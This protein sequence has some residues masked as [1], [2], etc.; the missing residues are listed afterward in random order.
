MWHITK[1]ARKKFETCNLLPIHE[2]D[3]EW[4]SA[5]KE[6][7]EEGEDLIAFLQQELEEV[8]EDLIKV[9]PSRF[10]PYLENGT[11]NQPTLPKKVRDD[12]LT[13]MR[14]K[15][16]EF[17]QILDAAYKNTNHAVTYLPQAVQEVFEE[18]LHD[19]TIERIERENHTL[20]LYINT[21]G[22]F[23]SKSM[24]HLILKDVIT[25]EST[26]PIQ[27]GQWFIYNELQ[28]T[29]EG[30]AFRVLYD[31]PDVEW[32]ITMKDMD[33]EYYYRPSLYTT[34]RD[35]DKLED[36]SI[37]EYLSKLNT[38][39]RYWFITPHTICAIESIDGDIRLENGTIAFGTNEFTIK[40]ESEC[41]NYDQEQINPISLIYTDTFENPYKQFEEPLPVEELETA[42]LGEDLELQVRAWNTMYASP[43]QLADIINHVLSRTEITEENEMMLSIFVDFFYQEGILTDGIIKKYH[44]LLD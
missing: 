12:Y 42:A 21:D 34:L 5:L 22:G 40:I 11:L 7:K 9:L 37:T 1:E 43:T 35:E 8:K 6:A 27:V 2:S 39:H 25:E 29:K 28:K 24:I 10:I 23:T 15:D 3:E 38:D 18:S 41:Y 30:F 26:E 33:A 19:A 13:W 36:T 4:E 20:H 17:V 16:N 32:T 44:T 14:E 31:V